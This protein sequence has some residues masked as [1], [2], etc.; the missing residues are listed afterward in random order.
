MLACSLKD[1]KL[2]TFQ[3]QSLKYWWHEHFYTFQWVCKASSSWG[4]AQSWI[5]FIELQELTRF[6]FSSDIGDLIN[7]IAWSPIFKMQLTCSHGFFQ[8]WSVL[9]ELLQAYPS[10]GLKPTGSSEK[11]HCGQDHHQYKV[12][13]LGDQGFLCNNNI[14]QF[15]CM[16]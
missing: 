10:F 6:S 5:S 9:F 11:W 8:E 15:S 2:L 1:L 12:P 16:P 13:T 14:V 4:V 7:P 3:R